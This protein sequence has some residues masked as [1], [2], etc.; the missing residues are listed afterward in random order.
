MQNVSVLNVTDD[1]KWAFVI[2][3]YHKIRLKF[4]LEKSQ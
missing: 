1:D 4:I 2:M 3:Y